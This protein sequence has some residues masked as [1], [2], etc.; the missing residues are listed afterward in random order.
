[1]LVTLRR[2]FSRRPLLHRPF[3]ELKSA[4]EFEEAMKVRGLLT[5]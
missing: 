5:I 3:A 2:R 1:M 4:E